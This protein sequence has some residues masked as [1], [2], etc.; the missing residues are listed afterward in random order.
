MSLSFLYRTPRCCHRPGHQFDPYSL[1]IVVEDRHAGTHCIEGEPRSVN[2]G[3]PPGIGLLVGPRVREL[4]RKVDGSVICV[5][6]RRL[7]TLGDGERG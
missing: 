6:E 2:N 5:K 3:S 7:M 4:L 1:W